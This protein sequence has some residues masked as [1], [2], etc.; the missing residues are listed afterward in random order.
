VYRGYFCGLCNRL[1]QNYG[2]PT[3]LLINRD[4]TF[5]TLLTAAQAPAAPQATPATCCNPLGKPRPLFQSGPGAEFAAATTICTLDTKLADDAEDER[6]P[7][8]HAAALAGRW[9]GHAVE[10]ARA[11]LIDTGFP[12]DSI[13]Q[14]MREQTARENRGLGYEAVLEPTA[15]AFGAITAHTARLADRPENAGP[16]EKIGRCLGELTYLLDAVEDESRDHARGRFNALSLFPA[17]KA[18]LERFQVCLKE[19]RQATADLSLRGATGSEEDREAQI[20][21]WSLNQGLASRV[22][23]RLA[24]AGW[25]T[26]EIF[27]SGTVPPGPVTAEDRRRNE[28]K[29]RGERR[30]RKKDDPWWTYCDCCTCDCCACSKLGGKKGCGGADGDACD[31]DCCPCDC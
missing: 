19:I 30:Q 14:L 15:Q 23:T 31:C 4:S 28:R 27:T 17:R 5:L 8:R 21:R 3:R 24:A 1:R 25:P 11:T 13:H 6:G 26:Q 16:L 9:L 2:L 29:R 20:T 18:A 22:E 7:R 10:R 12:A